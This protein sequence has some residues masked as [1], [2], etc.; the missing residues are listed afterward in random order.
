MEIVERLESGVRS[1]CR[2]FPAVFERAAG[3]FLYD[4]AGRRY[5][6]FF[7]GAGTLAYGHNHP[8]LKAALVEY[9]AGDGIAHGLDMATVAKCDFMAELERTILRPRGLDYRLQF[10]GP[11]GANAVEAALKLARRVKNRR[12][13][14]AFTNGYHGLSLGALAVTANRFYRHESYIDR[15]DV[16]FMPFDGFMGE[17]LDTLDLIERMIAGNGSGVDLPAAVIVETVQAEGG[18]NVASVA[19]LRRLAALCRK[20]GVLLIVD[21][22]QVGCGRTGSFFSFERAGIVPDIVVLSKAIGGFGLP[23][24]LVLIAPE[25]DCWAPGEHSGTFRGNNL[26]FVTAAEALRLWEGGELQS[27]IEERSRQLADG[28]HALSDRHPHLK[29]Q[30]RGLGMIYGMEIGHAEHAR[31]ISRAAFERGLLL[32]TCGPERNVL[33]LLPPLWIDADVLR[34]GLAVLE[35]AIAHAASGGSHDAVLPAG[36]PGLSGRHTGIGVGEASL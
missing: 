18:V 10:T 21:D 19:W 24:S 35:Q 23:M 6:D 33:K 29:A 9:L 14:V 1:Y 20:L 34:E 8:K 2:T 13:V 31:A 4:T 26:A 7:C 25:M 3:A 30:V 17:G 12:N 5:I 16:A 11:T 32:E 36:R 28:L 15:Q 27:S 22:I